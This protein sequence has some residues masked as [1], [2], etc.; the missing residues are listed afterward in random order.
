[1]RCLVLAVAL[2]CL[3]ETTAGSRFIKE[4]ADP[5][6]QRRGLFGMGLGFTEEMG[7]FAAAGDMN[8]QQGYQKG[9]QAGQKV[10]FT[11]DVAIDNMAEFLLDPDHSASATG[12]LLVREHLFASPSEKK[13]NHITH[14]HKTKTK[15]Y[16]N[17]NITN[18][19]RKQETQ[20]F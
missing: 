1:M 13:G 14:A 8:Y 2:C 15:G 10:S 3:V 17:K 19:Y 5:I 11:L 7:G 9:Q 20:T 4:E 16:K 6:S 12:S 18:K